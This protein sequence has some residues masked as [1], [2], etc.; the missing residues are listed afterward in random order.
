M[1]FSILH[2]T[3]IDGIWTKLEFTTNWWICICTQWL[4]HNSTSFICWNALSNWKSLVLI[5]FAL[6]LKL[7]RIAKFTFANSGIKSF[8]VRA[9]VKLISKGC[10]SK[11]KSLRSMTFESNSELQRIDESAFADCGLMQLL[12]LN[13]IQFLSG[14]AFVNLS[15]DSISFWPGRYEFQCHELFIE[16]IAGWSIIR[17]FGGARTF[18]IESKIEIICE[19]CFSYCTSLTSIA[20][21]SISKLHRIEVSALNGM[22]WQ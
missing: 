6:N 21:Q 20:F 1:E 5:A 8:Q 16:D 11:C 4:D 7:Q 17:S 3:D 22:V 19:Y 13:S 12:H 10:F 18:A 9:F 15:L 2:V 14:S